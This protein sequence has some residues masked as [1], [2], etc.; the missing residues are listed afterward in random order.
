MILQ[1]TINKQT[2][3]KRRKKKPRLPWLNSQIADVPNEKKK[4]GFETDVT[5]M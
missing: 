1:H 2:K 5:G 4:K 3:K